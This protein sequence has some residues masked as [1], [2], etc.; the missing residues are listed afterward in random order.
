VSSVDTFARNID[1]NVLMPWKAHQE[2]VASTQP[3]QPSVPAAQTAS[4]PDGLQRDD[5]RMPF[6]DQTTVASR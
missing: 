1:W 4:L 3:A 6:G 2:T 5:L